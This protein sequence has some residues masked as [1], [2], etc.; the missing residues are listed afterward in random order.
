MKF[1][2]FDIEFKDEREKGVKIVL[3]LNKF[4]S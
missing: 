2:V 4:Y 3:R 1:N